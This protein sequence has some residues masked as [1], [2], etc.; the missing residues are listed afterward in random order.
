MPPSLL[1]RR[2]YIDVN[3][4]VAAE[5]PAAKNKKRSYDDDHK[6]HQD[7]YNSSAATAIVS[8]DFPPKVNLRT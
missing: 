4:L 8:H 1:G 7:R 3:L 6:D 5:E 2:A